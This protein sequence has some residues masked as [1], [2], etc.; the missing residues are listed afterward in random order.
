VENNKQII[1]SILEKIFGSPKKSG[2]VKEYEFN[3]KSRVCR[4][5]EDKYN[6][7]YNSNNN[8]FQCWKCKYKGHI[9]KLVSD[10]GN[11][12]DLGRI[13][14]IIPKGKLLK[15]RRNQKSIMK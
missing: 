3:C 9:H 6:L 5:D 8:I 13:S 1:I 15:K 11:Q 10:Y 7:A 4:N 14:L 12:D 2:D